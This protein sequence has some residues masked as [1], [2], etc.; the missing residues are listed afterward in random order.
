M[1]RL[2]P[3]FILM[4]A[5]N[6]SVSLIGRY[7]FALGLQSTILD[8]RSTPEVNGGDTSLEREIDE[9]LFSEQLRIA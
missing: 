9:R 8:S 4:N 3:F 5:P 7:N 1:F 2:T 6:H